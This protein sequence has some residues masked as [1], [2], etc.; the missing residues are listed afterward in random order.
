MRAAVPPGLLERESQAA[1]RQLAQ[2]VVRDRRPSEV[3]DEALEAVTVVRTHPHVGV[4]VESGD[5][6]AAPAGD[7]G[8]GD[9]P[10]SAQAQHVT[11]AAWAGGDQTLKPSAGRLVS[12]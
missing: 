7:G 11:A 3:L 9:G 8:L 4:D 5:V 12:R 2:A 10:A 1:V 6:G